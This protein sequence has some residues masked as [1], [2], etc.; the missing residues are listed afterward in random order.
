M[1]N[2]IGWDINWKRSQYVPVFIESFSESEAANALN[3]AWKIIYGTYPEPTSLA[4]LFAH[5]ALETGRWKQIA[6]YNFGNI[7]KTHYKNLSYKIIEDDGHKWTM[8]ATGENK[9]NPET[10]K[11][12]WQWFEP[13]HVETHFRSY[14]TIIDGAVDYIRFLSQKTKY[15]KAWLALMEGDPSKYSKE[16]SIAGYY[17]ANEPKYTAGVVKI[18]NEFISKIDTLITKEKFLAPLSVPPPNT[19]KIKILPI[20][21]DITE[22]KKEKNIESVQPVI[23]GQQDNKNI[24]IIIAVGITAIASWLSQLF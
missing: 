10:K 11:T 7:K 22:L 1:D 9:Y 5:S 13:P 21:V 15:E 12:E 6:N 14:D 23:K 3:K 2:Y 17:T 16:L 24:V 18:F 20:P 8:F 4:I 19:E